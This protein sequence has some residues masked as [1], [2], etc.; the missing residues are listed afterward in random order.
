MLSCLLCFHVDVPTVW[1]IFYYVSP[2]SSLCLCMVCSIPMPP[3]DMREEEMNRLKPSNDFIQ[4]AISVW[5]PRFPFLPS[6]IYTS[7]R[8]LLFYYY[9]AVDNCIA[10][11]RNLYPH[12]HPHHPSHL[13]EATWMQLKLNCSPL[14][15][16]S[17]HMFQ[18]CFFLFFFFSSSSVL[19]PALLFMRWHCWCWIPIKETLHYTTRVLRRYPLLASGRRECYYFI[20]ISRSFS[21]IS[22]AME[23]NSSPSCGVENDG[24]VQGLWVLALVWC[25]LSVGLCGKTWAKGF[26]GVGSGWASMCW[27]YV[28]VSCTARLTW[29]REGG[30]L[31]GCNTKRQ[32]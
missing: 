21:T 6:C 30:G 27:K 18:F 15:S 25:S 8:R 32:S 14:W 26:G 19:L 16:S 29:E 2:T 4:M 23:N 12:H 3:R 17:C 24:K 31:F 5:M 13:I 9:F 20:A 1:V 28:S 10:K 11:R 7:E 22:P